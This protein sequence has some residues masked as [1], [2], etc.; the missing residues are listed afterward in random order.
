MHSTHQI[1]QLNPLSLPPFSLHP[2]TS[3]HTEHEQFLVPEDLASA[4][5]NVQRSKGMGMTARAG[6]KIC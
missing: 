6:V 1:E 5:S 2:R 3:F 4:K